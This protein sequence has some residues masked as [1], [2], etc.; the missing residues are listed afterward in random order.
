MTGGSRPLRL[1]CSRSYKMIGLFS[2]GLLPLWVYIFVL[3]SL[4]F[5]V[6]LQVHQDVDPFSNYGSRLLV[7]R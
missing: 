6:E 5:V 2:V 4:K 3:L 1:I 7:R